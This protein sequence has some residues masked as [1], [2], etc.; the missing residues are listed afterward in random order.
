MNSSTDISRSTRRTERRRQP[1]Y[2]VGLTGGIAS[3]KST[4]AGLFSLLGVAVI[5]TDQIARDVVQPGSSV[6]AAIV[7]RFG[8]QVLQADGSLDRRQLRTLV[9]ADDRARADLEALTHPAIADETELRSKAATGPYLL[10][11]VPLL[12]EKQLAHRYDRVLVV[13]CDPALQ[14]QR[15]M[16]RDRIHLHNGVVRVEGKTTLAVRQGQHV[17]RT[18][19]D[20]RDHRQRTPA[21]ARRTDHRPVADLVANQRHGKIV[22]RS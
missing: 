8:P 2:K 5:D 22:Q 10:I 6:L 15:L 14:G 4:V 19:G 3:G 11:A 20:G 13:D 7:A 21:G 9:F 17:A 16:L 1:A 12:A 18:P